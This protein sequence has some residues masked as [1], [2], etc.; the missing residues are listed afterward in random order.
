MEFPQ[1]I[2][3]VRMQSSSRDQPDVVITLVKVTPFKRPES[4]GMSFQGLSHEDGAKIDSFIE[5]LIIRDRASIAA[6]EKR[7]LSRLK[8]GKNRS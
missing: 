6:I 5:E 8:S 1:L 4:F 7:I 2:W 3:K